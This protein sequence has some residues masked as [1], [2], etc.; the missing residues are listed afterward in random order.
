MSGGKKEKAPKPSAEPAVEGADGAEAPKKKLAGKTLVLFVILPALL[1]VVGGGA[2]AAMLLGGKPAEAH[3]GAEAGG[4]KAKEEKKEGGEKP[5]EK[6]GEHAEKKEG[7]EGAK[8]DAAKVGTLTVG[9]NGEP[10]YYA[11]PDLLVNLS[12]AE[13]EKPL[14]LKLDLVLEAKDPA[15]FDQMPS[16]MPRV[17]DQFQGFLREL[18]VD[19]LSGSAGSYR[20]RL[21][22]LR[23]LNLAIAPKKV[24][25]VLIEGMLVQ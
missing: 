10:S 21:E 16:L 22:L 18:R 19:D 2:V 5:A 23:R 12:G 17:T 15:V 3:A 25:A 13:G 11:M 7:A 9:K 20:L 6:A 4:E 1:V 24:D 8:G 14:F